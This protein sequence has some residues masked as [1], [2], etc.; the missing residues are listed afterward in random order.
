[1]PFGAHKDGD[2]RGAVS[3]DNVG[4]LLRDELGFPVLVTLLKQPDMNAGVHRGRA[5][6]YADCLHVPHPTV[7]RRV[8][9]SHELS[10]RVVNPRHHLWPRT[11]VLGQCHRLQRKIREL[12]LSGPQKQ[13]HVGVPKPVNRLHRIP[14]H[15]Q[16]SGGSASSV[17]FGPASHEPLQEPG[18]RRGGVLKLVDEDMLNLVIQSLRQCRGHL[19]RS[20]CLYRCQRNVGVIDLPTVLKNQQ[21][22]R[23]EH[24]QQRRDEHDQLPGVPTA[25][26]G[27]QVLDFNQ[28]LQ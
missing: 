14:Y 21:Q 11:K 13:R 2:L 4:H 26:G 27:G 9:C 23:L 28:G 7:V 10:K 19:I 17:M 6:G 1:M 5:V 25:S 15:E 16:R 8:L 3:R 20:Q 12:P 22:V 24:W 18:L